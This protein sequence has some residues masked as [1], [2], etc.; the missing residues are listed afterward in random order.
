MRTV[1]K[2]KKTKMKDR[3][4]EWEEHEKMMERQRIFFY[5]FITRTHLPKDTRGA[6]LFN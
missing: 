4:R 3:K 5:I 6:Q 1:R 2:K